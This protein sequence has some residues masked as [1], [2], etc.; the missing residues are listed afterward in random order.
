MKK[1]QK[2]IQLWTLIFI[3]VYASNIF[4]DVLYEAT[5]LN[6]QGGGLN[7]TSWPSLNDGI[8]LV[9]DITVPEGG[10][11]ID[12]IS[13]YFGT[14]GNPIADSAFCVVYSKSILGI[15]NPMLYA[16]RV[17]V[18]MEVET[19]TDPTNGFTRDTNRIDA[20]GLNLILESGEYW[21]GLS[22]ISDS[23]ANCWMAWG[24]STNN[25]ELAKCYDLLQNA[26]VGTAFWT[27]PDEM[28]K[29]QGSANT[30][31]NDFSQAT[32]TISLY[33]NFPNPF[34]PS[35]T[36]KFSLKSSSDVKLEVFNQKGQKVNTLC[37]KMFNSGEHSVVWNGTDNNGCKVSSGVYFYRLT[38]DSQALMKKM[39]LLK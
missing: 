11:T 28:L 5:S 25:G 9:D 3:F 4:A 13:N 26:W 36:I 32:P 39:I 16:T 37:N 12:T 10:W 1:V 31:N 2:L 18:T 35:T 21:I 38:S 33:S 6:T 29:I 23:Y 27:G 15:V 24:S 17:P 14:I 34:N 20:S 19:F 8:I 22:P 30:E 7:A